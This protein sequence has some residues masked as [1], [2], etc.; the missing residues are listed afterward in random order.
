MSRL[1]RVASVATL[2]VLSVSMSLSAAT[3]S[4][5]QTA[6]PPARP[7]PEDQAAPGPGRELFIAHCSSCHSVDY[8][9]MHAPFGTRA[10]WESSVAKMRNAFK[11]P[12]GDEDARAIVEYLSL[13]YGPESPAAKGPSSADDRQ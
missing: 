8:I 4:S 6:Q 1:A 5:R 12:V 9:R 13:A 11:A 7:V 2:M 3:P 10:L